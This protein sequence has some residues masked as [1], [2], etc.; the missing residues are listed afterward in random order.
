MASDNR[1]LIGTASWTDATLL[2][3]GKFYPRE[4]KTAEARLRYYSAEFPIVEVD[5]T[6]YA[7][8]SVT[9]AALW[10]ERTPDDFV[11]NIKVFRLF[12]QHQTDPKV[13]PPNVRVMLG[14]SQS[15]QL[16]YNDLGAELQDELWRQFHLSLEPLR[17]AGKLGA[18]LF[19]FPKWF[20]PNRG[21]RVYME[22]IR[23][24][25]PDHTIALEFRHESW[26]EGRQRDSI[27]AFERE[28]GFCNVIVDEPQLPGSIPTVWEATLPGLAMVR[29]HGRNADTWNL[30]GLKAASD[31]FNYDYRDEELRDF[32]TPV[33]HLGEQAENVHMI[34][35]N[36]MED[37]GIRNA[38]TMLRLL[39]DSP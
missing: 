5:S 18:L 3:S 10:A 14:E 33:R 20:L 21:S 16:Y 11:F 9:N 1:I 26:F 13:L 35:N 28:L 39:S 30:K 34:F 22:Q 2:K 19:Q 15:R 12:T 7:M 23:Q 6:Y 37:Q 38:R 27:L 31:R 32:I 24:R 25:L 36:N 8:P 17:S 4:V 29:M